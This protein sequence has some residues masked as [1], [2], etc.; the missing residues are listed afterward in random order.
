LD[1]TAKDVVDAVKACAGTDKAACAA[2]ISKV[3]TYLGAATTDISAAVQDCV[4]TGTACATD[5]GDAVTALGNASTSISQAVED[6]STDKQKA[7]QEIIAGAKDIL[8]GVM[9]V[10]QAITDCTKST[11]S[12]YL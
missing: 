10:K 5:I 12:F 9:D 3:V 8:Q 6:W 2:A 1:A 4:G 7:E 11:P